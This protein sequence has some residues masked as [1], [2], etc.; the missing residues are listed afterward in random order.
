[1][2][3]DTRIY[4]YIFFLFLA[5]RQ[6]QNACIVCAPVD[7]TETACSAFA[8]VKESL[9]F[10]YLPAPTPSPTA[11]CVLFAR[12]QLMRMKSSRSGDSCTRETCN[13]IRF[14]VRKT[15]TT[16]QRI[17]HTTRTRDGPKKTAVRRHT[18]RVLIDT[19]SYRSIKV[20]RKVTESRF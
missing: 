3:G 20:F 7:K 18:N 12:D 2:R 5:N 1:M 6:M 11:D 13:G 4:I 8:R 17:G 16:K 19:R 15:Y 14:A 10:V 9:P